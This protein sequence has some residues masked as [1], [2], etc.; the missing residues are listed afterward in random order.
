MADGSDAEDK[1]GAESRRR[2][3][4]RS[5]S[6]AGV[7]ALNQRGGGLVMAR[8]RIAARGRQT[9]ALQSQRRH[10]CPRRAR[11]MGGRRQ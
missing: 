8:K 4:A 9:A 2:R 10:R 3:V 6:K 1:A 5:R 7:H 11:W